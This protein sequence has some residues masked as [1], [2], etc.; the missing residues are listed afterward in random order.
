VLTSANAARPQE[1]EK[2][3]DFVAGTIN[4]PERLKTRGKVAP[5]TRADIAAD[6]ARVQGGNPVLKRVMSM[7][8]AFHHSGESL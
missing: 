6:L 5:R 2:Q 4:V 7:G 8:V 3:A 1:C